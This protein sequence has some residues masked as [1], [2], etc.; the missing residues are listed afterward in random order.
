MALKIVVLGS[1]GRLGSALVREWRAE[2]HHVLGLSRQLLDI[3]NFS[4]V[5]E[6][7]G[8][9]DF[10]VLVN[11]AALTNVDYCETHADEAQRL[12][13]E[14]VATIA[15]VCSRKRARCIHISTD[16]VFD[17][18][19]T[20]PYT[21]DDEARPISVYGASK[22]AGEKFLHSVSAQ[23]LAVRVSWVFGPDRASFVDQILQNA[24]E[25][26]SV[27]AIADKVAVPTF[28]LD[29]ARLLRPFLDHVPAGGIVHLCNAGACTWQQYRPVRARC[30]RARWRPA[31]R[32]R[33]AAAR[34]GGFE[35]LRR[36]ASAEYGDE[37]CTSHHAHRPY[38]ASVA[39]GG[40]RICAPVVGA[41]A[42]LKRLSS[43]APRGRD[44]CAR[45]S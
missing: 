15:D 22:L 1:G 6:T 29:A 27:A 5:R 8:A 42:S 11:C 44:R 40:G 19:K 21:E 33:R 36:A 2:G 13:G 28:T 32:A 35:R 4:T 12:N 24:L 26:E 7:L 38:A 14:A 39:G 9:Q 41:T 31:S 3:G 30:R 10:D 23:H 37:H 16:Y 20:T 17:G 25:K 34:D 45:F 43:R 18:A